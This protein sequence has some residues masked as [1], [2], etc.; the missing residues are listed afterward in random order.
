MTLFK[1]SLLSLAPTIVGVGTSILTVPIYI[2]L[3]GTDRYGA[4]LIG[5]V[6]LGYFGR[7]DFG[8]GRAL[9][10]RLSFNIRASQEERATIVW[11]A[12]VGGAVISV[13]GALVVFLAAN[14]FFGSFFEADAALKSE[15]LEAG[16]LFALC[17]PVIIFTGVSTG[18]MV[19]LERFGIV[20]IAT[21]AGNFLSQVLP[22]VVA[23][24]YSTELSWLLG[25]SLAG[26]LISLIVTLASM[27][28]VFL[29]GQTLVTSRKQLRSLFDYG[30]WIM[31]TAIVGPLMLV[32][33]RLVIGAAVGAA[34]VVAYSVPFQIA[35][36]TATLPGS[37]AQALFPRLASQS[38][39]KSLALSKVSVV[40]VGQIYAYIV[41]GLICLAGPLLQLWLG[42]ALDPRSTLIGQIIIIGF[43]TNALAY[44]PFTMVQA[45]GN[46]RFTALIHLAELPLY[47][48]M[49]YGF[50][51][52][53]GLY[54][55]ALAFTLRTT[56]DCVVLFVK[57]GFIDRFLLGRLVGPALLIMVAFAA[58]PWMDEWSNGVIG[59]TILSSLLSLLCWFQMPFEIKQIVF[60]KLGLRQV[61]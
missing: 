29:H 46:S 48:C 10:Q 34:A 5:L 31:V 28:R 9:T 18:A 24:L 26:R 7:V 53:L 59:A 16:W 50:G 13:L 3:I 27:W 35:S 25:A 44:I 6:L 1:N 20:S 14:T 57:A 42:D 30:S 19:G 56:I 39:E 8:L 41:I 21:V 23:T 61:S 58:S 37:V 49:L 45:S 60:A 12:L 47:I 2:S 11:S 55:I 33:D 40:F 22:L 4:L 51:L 17:I 54:G 43:W 32:S 38:N 36:R 15:A 52:T